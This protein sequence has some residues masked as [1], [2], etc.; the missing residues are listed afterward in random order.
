MLL[1]KRLHRCRKARNPWENIFQNKEDWGEKSI[2]RFGHEIQGLQN[3]EYPANI[4]DKSNAGLTKECYMTAKEDL[5]KVLI[6]YHHNGTEAVKNIV[7]EV[8]GIM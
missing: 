5:I 3:V 2:C 1:L 8:P 6:I 7:S 4:E